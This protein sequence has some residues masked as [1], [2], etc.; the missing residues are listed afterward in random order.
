VLKGGTTMVRFNLSTRPTTSLLDTF[1]M[2]DFFSDRFTPFSS[3]AGVDVIKNETGYELH[4]D[5]PGVNK[6]DIIIDMKDDILSIK[7]SA[8][9][10]NESKEKNYVIR[11]RSTRQFSRSFKVAGVQE[12]NIHASYENGVLKLELP[13]KEKIE[14]S[15]K[16]EVK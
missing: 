15:R 12:D 9:E 2:D 7:V 5:L 11:Q 10:E 8:Q 1:F 3:F 6:D 13:F 16:I 4:V 14:V